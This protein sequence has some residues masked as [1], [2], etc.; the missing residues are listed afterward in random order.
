MARDAAIL[1]ERRKAR[2]ERS[3]ARTALGD[4]KVG[5][6]GHKKEEG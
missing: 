2:E 1:K 3:L 6:K 5:G 4:K